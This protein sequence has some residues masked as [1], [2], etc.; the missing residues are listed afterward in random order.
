[1]LSLFIVGPTKQPAGGGE[2]IIVA[3]Q[4][5][6]HRPIKLRGQSVCRSGYERFMGRFIDFRKAT[7]AIP[8]AG[9]GADFG[10]ESPGAFRRPLNEADQIDHATVVPLAQP[11]VNGLIIRGGD[12]CSLPINLLSCHS[13]VVTWRD[14]PATIAGGATK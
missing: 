8:R 12:A 2:R 13:I 4:C 11:L 1:M 3:S 7:R 6:A 5:L 9:R 14:T 10:Q